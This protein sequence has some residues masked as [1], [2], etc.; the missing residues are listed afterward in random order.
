[1]I[2]QEL[3]GC[4]QAGAVVLIFGP[5]IC[6]LRTDP[7]CGCRRP[8]SG[9]GIRDA[10]RMT[11]RRKAQ[12]GRRPDDGQFAETDFRPLADPAADGGDGTLVVVDITTDVPFSGIIWP[13]TIEIYYDQEDFDA[14]GIGDESLL[15]LYYWDTEQGMWRLCP[16]SGVNTDR[17]CV[18]AAAYHL[19]RFAIMRK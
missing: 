13:L 19:T 11:R 3:R 4:G 18:T 1:M 14:S 12:D 5:S 6:R 16:E 10:V 8:A 15:A 17:N 9:D 2:R 7:D